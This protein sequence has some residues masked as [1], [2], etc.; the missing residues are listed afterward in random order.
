MVSG[1]CIGSG[2]NYCRIPGGKLDGGA[3]GS[4]VGC[5]EVHCLVVLIDGVDQ[6]PDD[7]LC[8]KIERICVSGPA[9]GWR[10]CGGM[11]C[12]RASKM[13]WGSPSRATAPYCSMAAHVAAPSG[14]P[15]MSCSVVAPPRYGGRG[16]KGGGCVN[17]A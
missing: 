4:M 7:G 12:G 2:S 3:A 6:L 8:C 9:V 1:Q 10:N 17:V 5:Q 14:A 15:A 13:K 11:S 16:P